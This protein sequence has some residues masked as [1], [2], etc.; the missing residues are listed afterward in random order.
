MR[1]TKKSWE[2]KETKQ[3]ESKKKQPQNQRA[4]PLAELIFQ[5]L[6]YVIIIC[7]IIVIVGAL[8]YFIYNI[9]DDRDLNIEVLSEEEEDKIDDI[10]DMDLEELLTFHLTNR[11]YRA[12]TRIEYLLILQK[13]DLNKE[14]KWS[15]EKTNRDYI[16][17]L[18]LLYTSPSPRD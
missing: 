1:K 5:L 9:E 4:S 12:A 11:N 17:E 8:I 6:Y 2:V 18:C 13:L 7:I 10:K 15:I 16:S 14:I 3:K